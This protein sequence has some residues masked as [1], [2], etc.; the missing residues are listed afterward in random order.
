MQGKAQQSSC[1]GAIYT[2]QTYGAGEGLAIAEQNPLSDADS[3]QSLMFQ[4]PS[5]QLQ[6]P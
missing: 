6:I 3:L 4:I 5:L 1:S 2:P